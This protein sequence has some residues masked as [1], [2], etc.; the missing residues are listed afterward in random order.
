MAQKRL[1]GRHFAIIQSA[2]AYSRLRGTPGCLPTTAMREIAWRFVQGRLFEHLRMLRGYEQQF[3]ILEADEGVYRITEPSIPDRRSCLGIVPPQLCEEVL[4]E[5]LASEKKGDTESAPTM[6]VDALT[7]RI[8][9]DL[10]LAQTVN[11][12][13]LKDLSTL[14]IIERYMG[15]ASAKRE[16]KRL[17]EAGFIEETREQVDTMHRR[18]TRRSYRVVKTDGDPLPA[19]GRRAAALKTVPPLSPERACQL[20][21]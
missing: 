4:R 12:P 6:T 7:L 14:F 21:G 18:V 16:R 5:I 1:E 20:A 19:K 3:L 15:M 17:V 13:T 8:A 9:Q 2:L 11:G 10:A